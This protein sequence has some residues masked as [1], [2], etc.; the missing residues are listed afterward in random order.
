MIV[1][2]PEIID[3]VNNHQLA[4]IMRHGKWDV[5]K[6]HEHDNM[7][8]DLE[9]HVKELR[10]LYD[11]ARVT[12]APDITLNEK[13]AD[14]VKILPLALQQ[15]EMAFSR[16]NINGDEFKTAN[17]R[18]TNKKITADIIVH[19]A[20]EGSVEVG[21]SEAPPLTENIMFSKE[22]NLLL[23]AVAERLGAV[24]EQRQAE[25]ALRE[26]EEKFSK[27][28]NAS[29]NFVA[30]N[31]LKD[32]KFLEVNDSFTRITGYTREEA[33]GRSAIDLNMW[34]DE[35]EH[36]RMIKIIKENNIIRNQ[37]IRI[38][39]KSGEIRTGLY[40]GEPISISGES[41]YLHTI[42]DITEQKQSQELLQSVS[43]SSPLGIYIMQDDKLLYT[44]PQFQR[45]TG[46]SQPELLGRE[47]LSLVAIEDSDVVRSSAIYTLQEANPYPCEYR[48][49]NKTGQIKWVMQTVAPIHYE[50]KGAILGNIMD[51]TE[52]KYLERK[53]IEYE[54]LS[55]M[56]SDLLATVSHELRTPLATIKGYSTMILDYF[57]R[58]GT[59]ETKDYIKSIDNATDR[60]AKLVD[61]L[62]DTS[63]MDAGLLKLEKSP[64]SMGR[65]IQGVVVEA[66]MRANH[67]HI[68]TALDKKLSRVNID[69]KRIRQ[70]LDNLIDNA[71]KYSPQGTEILVSAKKTGPELLISVT[72]QGPGIPA[73][74]LTNI[75]DRMYRIEQRLYSGAD[76]IG[77]GLY[78]CQRLVEA[79]GGRIW[80]ESTLGKGST[81]KFTLPI[82]GMMNSKKTKPLAKH[83]S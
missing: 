2:A 50:G 42:T 9:K 23:D 28:F 78:I 18:D 61:N 1:K 31:R 41:C 75:F 8:Y 17:Y 81:I 52:R 20:K 11:I 56:K 49:L 71:I 40:S 13:L 34:A 82:T 72:D 73:D 25:E 76:G 24:A 22:E 58:L 19:G 47:L 10:C 48:I 38:R 83:V 45:I 27:A 43:Y 7:R 80:A 14:I 5:I 70:V 51:I 63:R 65:L 64:T 32:D 39:C 68:V 4:L 37:E 53:V 35:D 77:L 62:L 33:L 74:E 57:S 69:P 67:H 79:H 26:S 21:Y 46:Y 36:A 44:N 3:V 60:L 29:A 54:E 66:S 55:K 15:P 12:G 6:K 30:I 59:E 16:I